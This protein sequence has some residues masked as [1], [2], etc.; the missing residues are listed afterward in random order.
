VVPLHQ[1]PV[2]GLD[3]AGAGAG[4]HPKHGVVVAGWT[5]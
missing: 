2:G 4:G 1:G 5:L 3:L